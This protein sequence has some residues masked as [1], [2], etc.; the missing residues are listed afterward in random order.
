MSCLEGLCTLTFETPGNETNIRN[1]HSQSVLEMVLKTYS[2]GSIHS[3]ANAK[4]MISWRY[5]LKKSNLLFKLSWDK[6]SRQNSLS[7]SLLLGVN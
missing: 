2:L 6:D 7:F 1:V 4:V 5:V 3:C